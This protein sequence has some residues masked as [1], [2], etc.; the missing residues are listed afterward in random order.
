[1]WMLRVVDEMPK[2]CM[3]NLSKRGDKRSWV[4]HAAV[5]L[6]IQCPEYIV[7]EAWGLLSEEQQSK[8]NDKA[9]E[10]IT[11]WMKKNA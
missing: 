5:A 4:G 7:R 9:S 2:A 6:A 10:A 8:A 11:Y 3:H 1:M